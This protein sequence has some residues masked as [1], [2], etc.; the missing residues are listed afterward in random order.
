MREHAGELVVG[1]PIDSIEDI[2]EVLDRVDLGARARNDERVEEREVLAGVLAVNEQEVLATDGDDPHRIFRSVVIERDARVAKEAPQ[3]AEILARI[4]R[5]APEQDL[6][7]LGPLELPCE[8]HE[9]IKGRLRIL[10]P[11]REVLES[12]KDLATL[13]L[14]LDRVE[15]AD[16]GE[17]LTRNGDVARLEKL[18]AHMRETSTASS[19]AGAL[20]GVVAAVVVTDKG[21]LGVAE[22]FERDV[23][24]AA[25]RELITGELL[26]DEGPHERLRGLRGEL[27]RRL[28]GVHEVVAADRI[29]ERRAQARELVRGAMKQVVHGA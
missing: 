1:N 13:R 14:V 22:H 26:A 27:E 24:A 19:S 23:A 17:S 8:G 4:S 15:K 20:E 10:T 2:G 7:R 18:S 28:V 11:Q 25:E 9:P 21:S 29:E 12:A 6:R 16:D 3:I 5:C